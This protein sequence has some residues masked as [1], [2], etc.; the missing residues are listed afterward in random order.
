M[1]V[2]S[3]M[4]WKRSARA[5][6]VT[7]SEAPESSRKDAMIGISCLVLGS[8]S[9]KR[10]VRGCDVTVNRIDVALDWWRNDWVLSWIVFGYVRCK[11]DCLCF[12]ERS[13]GSGDLGKS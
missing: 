13:L 12:L 5:L 11:E 3:A 8:C 4:G 7:E 1:G 10:V 9:C 2:G 6:L